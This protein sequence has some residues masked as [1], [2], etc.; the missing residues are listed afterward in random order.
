MDAFVI[1][2]LPSLRWRHCKWQAPSLH[3]R[4]SA[5]SLLRTQ[6]PPSRLRPTSRFRRLYGLPCSGD[7]SPGRGGLL[8]LLGMSLSPCCRFHPAEVNSRSV[9]FRL[10][11]LPSPYGCGLDPRGFSLSRP[12]CVHCCYGPV[13]C[14][15]PSGGLVDRLRRLSFPLLRYPNYGALTSTPAALFPAEHASLHWTHNRTKEFPGID[16]LAGLRDVA[17]AT[18]LDTR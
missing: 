14:N 1:A 9:S 2:S 16:A 5:S 8:Q 7:F 4:Y 10:V 15:L 18:L 13:T 3:G 17:D 6:P 11:I 12:Q